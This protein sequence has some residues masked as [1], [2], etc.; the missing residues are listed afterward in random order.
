MAIVF[1]FGSKA[2]LQQCGPCLLAA[3]VHAAP[4]ALILSKTHCTCSLV[5]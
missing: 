2:V 1:Q 4:T 3:V 5:T